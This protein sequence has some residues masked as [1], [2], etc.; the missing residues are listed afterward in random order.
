MAI[1]AQ[2][3]VLDCDDAAR[4]GGSRPGMTVAA[5]QAMVPD[6]ELHERAPAEGQAAIRDLALWA[7]QFSSSIALAGEDGVLIEVG[8]SATYFG[9]LRPLNQRIAGGAAALGYRTLLGTAPA[10][11]GAILLARAAPVLQPGAGCVADAARARALL[12]RLPAWTLES[13]AGAA[14]TLEALGVRTIADLLAL[15]RAG[16]QRRFGA[17][18]LDELDRALGAKPDPRAAFV[19]PVR[20]DSHLELL[21]PTSN[22]ETLLFLAKRLIDPLGGFLTARR[23]GLREFTLV[24]LHERSR[25][26]GVLPTRLRIELLTSSDTPAH[27]VML[28]RERLA[29][30]ALCAPAVEL[31]LEAHTL[32]PMDERPQTLWPDARGTADGLERLIERLSARLGPDAVRRLRELPDHRPERASA[33]VPPV[34]PEKTRT[35]GARVPEPGGPP[36]PRP[37]WIFEPAQPL[38]ESQ[39]APQFEGPLRLVRGP[40]RI[41]SGWWDQDAARDYFVARNPAGVSVWVYRLRPQRAADPAGWFLH[42]L[43]A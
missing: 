3:K 20:Y 15:P 2:R 41:E 4:A 32:A 6:L 37:F 18:L 43:F 40:E 30:Q 23:A 1:V 19:A 22:S 34:A 29:R 35:R 21:A 26:E 10:P 12:A 17:A 24:F 16:V 11:Q 13:A 25:R 39:G 38:E 36:L 31:R 27:L 8:A 14:Q 33:F 42:G 9:G 28:L 7:F 5:A